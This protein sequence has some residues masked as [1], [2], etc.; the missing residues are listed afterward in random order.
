MVT[1]RTGP[2]RRGVVHSDDQKAALEDQVRL[3]RNELA[4]Y[5]PGMARLNSSNPEAPRGHT[6]QYADT[7][8]IMVH[9]RTVVTKSI[10]LDCGRPTTPGY[11]VRSKPTGDDPETGGGQGAGQRDG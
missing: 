11:L 8:R 10:Y 3:I 2:Y 7:K 9:T 6:V 4:G 5:T 1:G